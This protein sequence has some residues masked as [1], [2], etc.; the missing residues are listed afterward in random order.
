M[1]ILIIGGMQYMTGIKKKLFFIV[2]VGIFIALL[3]LGIYKLGFTN[4]ENDTANAQNSE[5]DEN[6][7]AGPGSSPWDGKELCNNE[8]HLKKITVY[9]Q[10]FFDKD[11]S[12]QEFSSSTG[13]E[14]EFP[15]FKSNHDCVQG[16]V[17][18][19]QRVRIADPETVNGS[20][21]FYEC[22][23]GTVTVDENGQSIEYC[24][25][26]SLENYAESPEDEE[27]YFK[28]VSVT[29]ERTQE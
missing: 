25:T 10:E 28:M 19:V 6:Y 16:G 17:V 12:E 15:E 3:S 21:M 1:E 27:G 23:E 13:Y 14:S 24:F 4:D 18:S 20:T 8:E 11:F 29:T 5:S 22:V 2:A 7:H 26:V 9:L